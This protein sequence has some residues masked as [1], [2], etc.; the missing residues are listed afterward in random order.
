MGFERINWTDRVNDEEVLIRKK[1][2]FQITIQNRK[3]N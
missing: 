3:G 1:E 2:K